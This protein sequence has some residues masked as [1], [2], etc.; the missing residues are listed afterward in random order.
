MNI[1][2]KFKVI[3]KTESDLGFQVK[4]YPVTGGS[5]ENAEFYRYTPAG[6]IDLTTINKSAADAFE[7]GKSYYVDFSPEE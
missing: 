5:P 1:R 4:M 6:Q 2:A 7:V 3:E